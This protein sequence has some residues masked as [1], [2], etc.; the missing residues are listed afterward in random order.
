MGTGENRVK[1]EDVEREI[2]EIRGRMGSKLEE[3]TRRRRRMTS[4]KHRLRQNGTRLG[5][6]AALVTGLVAAVRFLR[7]RRERRGAHA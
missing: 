5:T 7:R 1:P 4:W 3:L 6:G 2:G